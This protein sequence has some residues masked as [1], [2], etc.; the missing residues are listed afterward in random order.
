MLP[1]TAVSVCV[2]VR[3]WQSLQHRRY[4][5]LIPAE[6]EKEGGEEEEKKRET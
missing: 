2:C 4:K 5:G 6:R 3:S 1:L